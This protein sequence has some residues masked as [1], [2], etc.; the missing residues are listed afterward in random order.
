MD[1][2][3]HGGI[4]LPSGVEF[5]QTWLFQVSFSEG[6]IMIRGAYLRTHYPSF[7][8]DNPEFKTPELWADYVEEHFLA[9]A[10][11]GEPFLLVIRT[12]KEHSECGGSYQVVPAR[13][14][15]VIGVLSQE[16][17]L[18]TRSSE[19][20]Y[21]VLSIHVATDR[22]I[23]LPGSHMSEDRVESGPVSITYRE[24]HM[25]PIKDPIS[26]AVYL[27]HYGN[28]HDAKKPVP[29]IYF[30]CGIEAMDILRA[31]ESSRRGKKHNSGDLNLWFVRN[32]TELKIPLASDDARAKL[33][34]AKADIIL[35]LM[36]TRE[37]ISDLERYVASMH[38]AAGNVLT[39]GITI[40]PISDETH[41]RLMTYDERR[42]IEKAK[43]NVSQL[44]ENGKK[45]GMLDDHT[46]V[47]VGGVDYMPSQI[48]KNFAKLFPAPA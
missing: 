41:A 19:I 11:P 4:F 20:G 32:A 35:G 46:W 27:D 24:M 43:K 8:W 42:R 47:Q 45:I 39:D 1:E 25:M 14:T 37:S 17:P 34:D 31:K 7:S 16:H 18:I 38:S 5:M 10:V 13:I 40:R 48:M 30:A 21:G 44:L 29:A 2:G 3:Q 36:K 22:C 28:L 15:Y 26:I 6:K 23:R 9:S 12:M 33:V